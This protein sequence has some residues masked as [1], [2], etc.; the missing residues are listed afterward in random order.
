VR[1]I[2]R[3]VVTKTNSASPSALSVFA[4]PFIRGYSEVK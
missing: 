1:P 3:G 2:G 4:N